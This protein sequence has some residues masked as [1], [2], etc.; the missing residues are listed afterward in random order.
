MNGSSELKSAATILTTRRER[1]DVVSY[2]TAD[3]SG[4]DNGESRHDMVGPLPGRQYTEPTHSGM[5]PSAV[6]Y[7]HRR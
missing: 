5:P 1:R 3:V 6:R 4:D 7:S 2:L